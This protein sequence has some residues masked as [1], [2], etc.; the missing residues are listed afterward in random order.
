MWREDVLSQLNDRFSNIIEQKRNYKGKYELIDLGIGEDKSMPDS[1][2]ISSIKEG[3]KN[4]KNHKYS[5]AGIKEFIDACND[6]L[7]GKN[8]E[9]GDISILPIMG[10]K[11]ILAILPTLFIEKDDIVITTNPSYIVLEKVARFYHGKIYYINLL[12]S[13][14]KEQ[15]E[16]IPLDILKKVKIFN[17][18]FPHNPTGQVI[19]KKEYELI[20]S[21]AKQ[22]N[23]IVVN[24]AAYID[25]NY[26]DVTHFL[27]VEDACKVGVEI[28]TLS[29]SYNMTGYRVGFVAGNKTIID[30]LT[31]LK[32]CF[33]SGQ[34]I[35][36]LLAGTYA[37]KHPEINEKL[38]NKYLYR[39]KKM[40]RIFSNTG[41]KVI[42]PKATFYLFVKVPASFQK[43]V[44]FSSFLLEEYGIM[45]IPYDEGGHHIRISVTFEGEEEVFKELE[46][47]LSNLHF[48]DS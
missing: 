48:F 31:R 2:I 10:A 14:F 45:T 16:K 6:Y 26:E 44:D 29:K 47:R 40:A 4:C 17:L 11:S 38:K 33:D 27:Q 21:L 35:P 37:L 28:Y 5:D 18:N 19:G 39:L 8:I 12:E 46:K 36:L 15:I 1:G 41:L 9:I 7:L 22:Y 23:F 32:D 42:I 25:I 24:D 43:A 3:L 30:L 13:S 20:I 34:F